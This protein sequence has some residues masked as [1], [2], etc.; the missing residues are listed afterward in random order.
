MNE[1]GKITH[2]LQENGFVSLRH[3]AGGLENILAHLGH[4]VQKTQVAK[5]EDSSLYIHGDE[6]IA[7]HTEQP[8]IPIMLWQCIE[9]AEHGGE[10]V[11]LDGYALLSQLSPDDKDHLLSTECV[12]ERPIGA[13]TVVGSPILR[14]EDGVHKLYYVPWYMQ[15]DVP[16]QE[17]AKTIMASAIA[18][19]PP[20]VFRMEPGDVVIV[21]NQRML[22]ARVGF[23]GHRVIDRYLVR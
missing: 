23:K 14:T 9:Q 12:V 4:V 11:L 6:D 3:H 10:T 15:E 20:I 16:D 8:N 13:D 18:Q 5:T 7:F 1:I 17:R 2:G 19:V 21:N 22:H